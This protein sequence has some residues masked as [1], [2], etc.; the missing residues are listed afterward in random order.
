MGIRFFAGLLLF[1]TGTFALSAADAKPFTLTEARQYYYYKTFPENSKSRLRELDVVLNV[2]PRKDGTY[3]IY[4][5]IAS[6][7]GR[8][9]DFDGFGELGKDGK[10]HFSW[11]NSFFRAN[12]GTVRFLKN[13]QK[14]ALAM[15]PGA[16]EYILNWTKERVEVEPDEI[17]TEP[18]FS[19]PPQSTYIKSPELNSDESASLKLK[20]LQGKTVS[21]SA[22]ISSDKGHV[23]IAGQGEWKSSKTIVFSFTDKAKHPGVGRINFENID[24]LTLVLVYNPRSDDDPLATLVSNLTEDQRTFTRLH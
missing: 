7:P 21:L 4:G 15:Y 3:L 6:L 22:S 14:A 24:Q 17:A 5:T 18:A 10:I 9:P 20:P 23:D 19:L 11:L 12:D 16:E 13:G 2:I 8:E 1:L